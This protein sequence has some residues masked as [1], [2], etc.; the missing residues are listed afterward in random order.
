MRT[1]NIDNCKATG[2]DKDDLHWHSLWQMLKALVPQRAQTA[3]THTNKDTKLHM[4]VQTKCT[5]TN[6]CANCM[7]CYLWL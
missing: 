4:T 2:T 3:S 6:D 5:F 1:S 7:H